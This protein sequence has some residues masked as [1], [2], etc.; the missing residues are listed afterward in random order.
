MACF[1]KAL[2]LDM[3]G[4]LY[5][6]SRVLPHATAFLDALASLPRVFV[7]N[8]PIATPEQV[9]G[10]LAHMGF[11]GPDPDQV[12]TSGVA[13][14]RYLARK[15]PGY[16]YFAVGGPGLDTELA[17]FGV[18]DSRQADFVVVGEGPG[19]DYDSLTRGINLILDRGAQLV[20]TNPDP[21]VDT[22]VDGRRRVLPGGGAL[23][24]PFE[25]A[26]GHRAISIGKPHPL[27]FEMALEKL[28]LNASDC[29]MV[30]D[31]V[32]TDI[33]GAQAVGMRTALVRSG[34]FPPGES[35]PEG[36]PPADWDV[37][38]LRQLLRLWQREWPECFDAEGALQG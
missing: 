10:K 27:L 20:S 38:D 29:V 18:A 25:V 34:R 36:Q 5:H 9:A 6:G 11:E 16:R 7:T 24:A 22:H 35:W 37:A 23:V 2:L 3:D 1:P 15:K 28:G 19:L 30:G 26:T 21:G 12:I 13:T 33:A 32:D 8:N 31:R 14:A 17:R 4:V